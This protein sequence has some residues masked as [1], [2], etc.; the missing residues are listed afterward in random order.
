MTGEL[1]REQRELQAA[2]DAAYDDL[3]L[4]AALGKIGAPARVGSAALGLMVTRDLDID[5]TC[6]ALDEHTIADISRLGAGLV[7]HPRVRQVQIRDDTGAWNVDPLYPDGVYLG[8]H[9]R[10]PD[11]NDWNLDVWFIDQ[12]DRQPSTVH[13]RTLRPRLTDESRAAILLIKRALAARGGPR[14]SSYD[15]YTAVLDDGVRT[16][17]EFDRRG[18]GSPGPR[19]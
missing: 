4:A 11:G 3:G 8:V 5:V 17:D 10:A 15:I 18:T 16:P 13:L 12:P 14:V 7:L 1:L 2:A 6:A 9:Y 19:S